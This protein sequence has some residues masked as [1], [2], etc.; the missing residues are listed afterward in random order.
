MA[1]AQTVSAVTHD[2]ISGEEPAAIRFKAYVDASR[3]D[4]AQPSPPLALKLLI[5][6]RGRL[7]RAR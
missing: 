2:A 6:A 5:D 7:G 3:A 4:P 1:H